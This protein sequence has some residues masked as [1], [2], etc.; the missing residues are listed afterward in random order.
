MRRERSHLGKHVDTV[1]Y[2]KSGIEVR[3]YLDKKD[4]KFR[5]ELNGERFSE[6]SGQEIRNKILASLKTEGFNLKWIPVIEVKELQPWTSEG[7]EFVGFSKTKIWY[8]ERPDKKWLSFEDE[9]VGYVMIRPEIARSSVETSC[10][11]KKLPWREESSHFNGEKYYLPYS[12]ELWEGLDSIED[13]L[14]KLRNRLKE[15]IGSKDGT[16]MIR[17]AGERIRSLM[18]K[19]GKKEE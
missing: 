7:G 1:T 12:A 14:K 9:S 16:L 19:D 10:P 6:S 15:L 13:G 11:W 8:A 5:A 17:N 18:L 3:I 4:M 2:Y